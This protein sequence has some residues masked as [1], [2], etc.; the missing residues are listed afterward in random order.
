MNRCG[1]VSKYIGVLAMWQR[2]QGDIS[3]KIRLEIAVTKDLGFTLSMMIS[4]SHFCK[5]KIFGYFLKTR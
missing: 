2:P 4:I 3:K 1:V 5:S